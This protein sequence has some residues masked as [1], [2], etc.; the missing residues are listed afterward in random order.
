MKRW[1]KMK[2]IKSLNLI[3]IFLLVFS[4]LGTGS[5]KAAA[6]SVNLLT[7]GG[8]ETSFWDDDIWT[9][10]ADWDNTEIEHMA[11]AEDEWITSDAGLYVLKYWIVD[12]A[13]EPKEFTINQT[14][15]ELPVGNYRLSVNSMGGEKDEAGN[16]ILFA[17]NAI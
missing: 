7:N 12:T 2:R 5:P 8:F 17:D 3:L 6:A 4:F 15:A 13:T 14:L 11:Y 10:D 16:L 9:I 1:N